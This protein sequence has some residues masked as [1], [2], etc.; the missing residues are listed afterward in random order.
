MKR[1]AIAVLLWTSSLTPVLAQQNPPASPA[2]SVD[3]PEEPNLVFDDDG[4]K[5][6]IVPA[7]LSVAAEKKF[8]G[9]E[10]M[11]SAQQVSIFLGSGWGDPQVRSRQVAIHDLAARPSGVLE[12]L[13]KNHVSTWSA[14]PSV[15][16]FSD[17]TGTKVNDL[18]IQ[19]KLSDW[20]ASKAIPAP[21][22]SLI[23]VIFLAPGVNS[24]LGAHKGGLE[25]AAYHNFVHLEA[26]EVRYVVV[27]FS[28]Q[29]DRHA[30]AAA[31]A[32]ADTALNPNGNGWY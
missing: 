29:A 9:G 10:V 25:Y 19:R 30:A 7:D 14:L 22:A 17:L 26:G 18:T 13:K 24:S 16:D 23:Y 20:L 3:R 32:F 12:E 21:T 27:P 8:H 4:G 28:D 11:Q 5:A 1:I 6:Q 31:R 15:E 2:A